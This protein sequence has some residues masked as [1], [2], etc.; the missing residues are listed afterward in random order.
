M[1]KEFMM[2]MVKMVVMS[3][4]AAVI[5]GGLYIPTQA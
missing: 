5:L 4:I 2:V 3:V 1:K